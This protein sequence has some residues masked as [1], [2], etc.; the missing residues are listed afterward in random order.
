MSEVKTAYEGS[1][2][3]GDETGGSLLGHIW[4]SIG[5][6][7]VLGIICCGIYP[8]IVYGIGQVFFP[9]QANGSLVKKDGTPTSDDSQA[10]GSSLIGQNFGAAYYFH[11]RPSAAGNGYDATS[12]GGTNLGPLSDK[13]IN[14]ATATQ[15][16]P[17]P[18]TQPDTQPTTATAATATAPTTVATAVA[19]QAATT[20]AAA[21][22]TAPAPVETLAFDGIRLR[23]I[24]YCLD[25]GISFKL[26][27]VKYDKEGAILADSRK[28]LTPAEKL[29]LIDADGNVN[30]IAMVD[31]FPHMD[32]SSTDTV[33]KEAI[34]ADGFSTLVPADAVTASGSGLDPHISPDNAVLQAQRVMDERNKASKA[35]LTKDQVLDLIKRNTDG[36]NLGI[37]GDAG[38]NVLMLN[39]ALDKMAPVPAPATA[40]ASAPASAPATTPA[41]GPE[42]TTRK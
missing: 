9:N 5:A 1:H 29:K 34:I 35:K 24:H 8:L 21:T 4:A 26:Y 32:M 40:P 13:L 38:V 37:L 12:S 31:A 17:A 14:G 23:V 6:T 22:S 36:P 30:D 33:V 25:N 11:P 15:P 41:T 42:A 10:V 20:N 19:T 16:A 28:E 18:A 3:S 27:H 39:I 2:N 7:I